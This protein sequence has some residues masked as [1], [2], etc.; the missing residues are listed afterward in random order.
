VTSLEDDILTVAQHYRYRADAEN[1]FDEMK[2]Q[3]GWG[4]FTTQDMKRCQIMARINALVY[5]WWSLFVRLAIPDKH[6]EAITSRPLLLTAIAKQTKHGGQTTLSI[7]SL[8]GKANKAQHMLTSLAEFLAHIRSTA[9][10]L[11]WEARW[12]LIL[13]RVF[14]WFLK[15]RLLPIP[16]LIPDT[17]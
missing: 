14:V 17:S 12:R 16:L 6:A 15:G 13:S 5:N 7:T 1:N 9:E 8:H 10:Q 11:S 2:N 3:W 4:G